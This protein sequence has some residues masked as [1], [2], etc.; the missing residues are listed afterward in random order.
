MQQFNSSITYYDTML[1][2]AMILFL[3]SN[4]THQSLT[5]IPLGY[6]TPAKDQGRCG[7]C[8]AFGSV[9]ALEG[10]HK[11]TTGVLKNFAEQG[12]KALAGN[13]CSKEF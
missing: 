6:V 1:I 13:A 7:S 10:S 9:V 8:W 12:I 3:C 5:M 4:S 11:K 2:Q